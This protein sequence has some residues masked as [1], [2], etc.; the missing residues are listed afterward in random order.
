[1][2]PDFLQ[3]YLYAHI[4]I[5]QAMGVKVH[6]L[7]DNSVSLWAPLAPNINHRGTAFGGSIS[8]L[9]TL[10]AWSLLRVGVHDISPLPT[11]VVRRNS[12]E[13]LKPIEGE[14]IATATRPDAESWQIFLDTLHAR[15]R[16][17]LSLEA[18]VHY[19]DQEAASF[20]GVFVA[21]GVAST[22]T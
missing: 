16:A 14:F 22:P 13:Y 20:S 12:V 4:P 18:L 15:G 1:M 2:N 6:A 10:S 3:D 7:T 21:L 5:S 8:T 11:L 17:R 19:A 9:A